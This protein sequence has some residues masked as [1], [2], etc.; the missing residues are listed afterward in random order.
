VKVLIIDDHPVARRGLRMI[1]SE[2]FDEARC[3]EATDAATALALARTLRPDLLLLDMHMP[4]EPTAPAL[5]RMMRQ[6]LPQSKIVIVTAF[7][8][9]AEIRDCL[10]AGADGCLLKDTSETDMAAALRATVTGAPA[11]DPRIA[12]QLARDLAD[13]PT[14]AGAPHL[15]GRERDVLRLLADGRSNRAIARQ[16]GLSEATVKGHV[17]RL[18]DKLNASSRLEAVVRATSTGL[19]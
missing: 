7:D 4:G 6:A 10:V 13:E 8:S 1:V 11:L 2:A 17:S 3:A 18:L 9:S 14:R 16:L 12:F 5:C 19:I 15:S